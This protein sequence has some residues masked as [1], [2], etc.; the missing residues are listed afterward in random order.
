MKHNAADGLFTKPSNLCG[1]WGVIKVSD[2]VKANDF[3]HLGIDVGSVSVNTVLLDHQKKAAGIVSIMPFTCMPG[4]IVS[5]LLKRCKEENNNIPYLNLSYDGQTE[6]N[7]LTRLE[8][9]VCQ[10]RRYHER[11]VNR[12]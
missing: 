7:T 1:K 12:Q 2:V 8:A 10:V 5:A 4:T 6:T 9:F 11:H 3:V